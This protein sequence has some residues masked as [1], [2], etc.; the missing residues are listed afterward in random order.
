M[1]Y[2]KIIHA[3]DIIGLEAKVNSELEMGWMP[4]GGIAQIPIQLGTKIGYLVAQAMINSVE[5]G[6][7]E[8]TDERM[9]FG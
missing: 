9:N 6:N 8:L 2:Y 1:K 3:D 7:I 5:A 4:Q